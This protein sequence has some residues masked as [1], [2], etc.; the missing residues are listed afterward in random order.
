MLGERLEHIAIGPGGCEGDRGFVVVGEQPPGNGVAAPHGTDGS[1]SCGPAER[2][3]AAACW[4]SR[5]PSGETASDPE[6]GLSDLLERHVRLVASDAPARGRFAATGAHH[7]VAPIHFMTTGTLEGLGAD[8]PPLSAERPAGARR[9]RGRAARRDPARAVRAWGPGRGAA[10]APVRRADPG[11]RRA[12]GRSPQLLRRIVATHRI[13]L[14]PV[15]EPGLRRLLRGGAVRGRA[16]GRRPA[17]GRA[18]RITARRRGS[19]I[20]SRA[21]SRS[22]RRCSLPFGARGSAPT[23]RTWVMERLVRREP[24]MIISSS[25][26]R[27]G[28]K[29]IGA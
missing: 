7:D 23:T 20:A 24:S 10:D 11:D 22:A 13:D 19:A 14:G 9:R 28:S 12:P 15:G 25:C 27:A 5:S 17:H 29:W 4:P 21:C 2:R 8:V 18:G 3:C 26:R 1:A 16:R 6:T